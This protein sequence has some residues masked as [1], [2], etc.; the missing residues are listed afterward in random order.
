MRDDLCLDCSKLTGGACGKHSGTYFGQQSIETSLKTLEECINN[1]EIAFRK[2][3]AEIVELRS[4]IWFIME[5]AS[6]LK[7]GHIT[8]LKDLW[9]EEKVLSQDEQCK[10][11]FES[12]FNTEYHKPSVKEDK[13]KEILDEWY[14]MLNL[15]RMK[16]AGNG[17]VEGMAVIPELKS[18]SWLKDK[19]DEI[20]K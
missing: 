20:I 14:R 19:L 15:A 5:K 16:I 12:G 17:F 13:I 4:M 7:D 11:T 3:S 6:N 18:E 8:P 1:L 9:E 2:Q 10:R